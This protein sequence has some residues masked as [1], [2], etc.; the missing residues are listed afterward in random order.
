MHS[1]MPN[2]L[3][4]GIHVAQPAPVVYRAAGDVSAGSERCSGGDD[5][6]LEGE[7]MALWHEKIRTCE[8]N[9]KNM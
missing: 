6:A 1:A 7:P 8:E 9:V 4:R 3:H 2:A 5:A